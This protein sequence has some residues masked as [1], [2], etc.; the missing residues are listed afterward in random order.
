LIYVKIAL[1]RPSILATK[2]KGV[3][4]GRTLMFTVSRHW[5]EYDSVAFLVLLVGIALVEFIVWSI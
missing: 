2:K 5:L 3:G 4:M 1:T